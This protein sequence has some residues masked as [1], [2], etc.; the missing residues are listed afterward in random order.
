[1]ATVKPG[2]HDGGDKVDWRTFACVLD[3][4]GTVCAVSVAT[5]AHARMPG[6]VLIM[7][8]TCHRCAVCRFCV[9]TLLVGW[10]GRAGV[11]LVVWL[12]LGTLRTG[13]DMLIIH[14]ILQFISV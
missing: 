12:G 1:M 3:A 2:Q 6:V 14:V 4:G 10:M 9:P 13:G 7:D 11:L 5:C 8:S